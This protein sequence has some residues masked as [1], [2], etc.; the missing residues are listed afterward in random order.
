MAAFVTILI[1]S[2]L[3]SAQKRVLLPLFGFEFVFGAGVLFFP[4]SYLFG[5][6]L[7]EVYGYARS[8]KVVWA[9]FT[10]IIFASAMSWVV[11][12]LPADP[13]WKN[14]AAFE[15][16]FGNAPRIVLASILAFFTGEF[17]NSFVLAKIKIQTQGRWLWVRTIGSTLVG[18]A[19]DSLIFYPIAFLGIW[20]MDRLVTVLV[21][22]YCLK[23]GWEVVA[24]PLTY[25]VVGFLKR[26][27]NEDYYDIGT[28]FTPFSL[29]T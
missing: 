8:R 6:I 23:V 25:K 13:R 29:K 5:D 12:H 27:E 15:A 20:E 24:T 10:A 28:D 16:V 18:E 21:T 17:V 1:C 3:I 9:G 2:N 26:V 11:I 22:N 7:T 4:I 14:Q 19:A